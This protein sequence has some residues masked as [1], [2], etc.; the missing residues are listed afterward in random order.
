MRLALT[1]IP[2][3]LCAET[4]SDAERKSVSDY[5]ERTKV[6]LVETVRPLSEAQYN[7]K[8]APDRWSIRECIE[9]ITVTERM[10]FGGMQK[11]LASPAPEG[12][13]KARDMAVE[14]GM[15]DRSKKV[16]AP[17]ELAPQG[18]P[19]YATPA[20]AIERFEKVRAATSGFAATTQA[21]LRAHG[22][23]HPFF[24]MLDLYQWTL[25]IA[26][27]SERHT[28]QIEEVMADAGFPKR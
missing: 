24:G 25:G 11:A 2:S 5:L 14:K 7:Y 1:L 21:D 28:K 6:K 23:P 12:L 16:K 26:A 9:H 8:S 19:E 10:I 3:L 15:P 18:L 4:I 22:F 27:H 20:Q 17:Q 13:T